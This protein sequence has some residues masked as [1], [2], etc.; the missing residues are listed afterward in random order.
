MKRVECPIAMQL[1]ALPKAI[2]NRMM[3]L[4]SSR[5][6]ETKWPPRS[7]MQNVIGW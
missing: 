4:L 3:L 5:C 2:S 7:S 1:H 6:A